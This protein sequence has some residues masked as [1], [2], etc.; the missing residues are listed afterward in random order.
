LYDSGTILKIVQPLIERLVAGV[1]DEAIR[2]QNPCRERPDGVATTG[3]S[4]VAR[5][6]KPQVSEGNCRFGLRAVRPMRS[7]TAVL[8]CT[9]Q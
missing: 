2:C 5:P 1:G 9:K 4:E 7:A 6:W 8:Q 3:R